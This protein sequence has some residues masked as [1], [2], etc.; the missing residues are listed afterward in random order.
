MRVLWSKDGTDQCR[1]CSS[2]SFPTYCLHSGPVS[3]CGHRR[4]VGQIEK[5]VNT[6]DG[7]CS[8]P[9]CRMGESLTVPAIDQY[10]TVRGCPIEPLGRDGDDSRTPSERNEDGVS[11]K[12]QAS[13][14]EPDG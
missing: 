8:T 3:A 10:L 9:A 12:L 5:S 14:S 6:V 1:S 13:G 11:P 4:T 7:L 2:A